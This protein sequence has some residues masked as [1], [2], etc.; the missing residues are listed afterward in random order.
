M[1]YGKGIE[2]VVVVLLLVSLV[3]SMLSGDANIQCSINRVCQAAGAQGCASRPRDAE[4][5][6]PRR[7]LLII[8]VS[9]VYQIGTRSL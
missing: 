6:S 4:P 8:T 2:T 5:L 9:M 7:L 3:S 1:I